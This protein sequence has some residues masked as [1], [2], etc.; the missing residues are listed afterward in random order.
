MTSGKMGVPG[1]TTAAGAERGLRPEYDVV[2]AGA[3]CAGAATA[4][5][6]ARAGMRVLMIDPV[7]RGRDA[8]STHA[9]M[10]GAVIQLHRWGLL[11]ALRAGGTPP[12]PA[13]TFDYGDEV[14][15]VP[16]KPSD[17]IDALYAPRRT[18][19]DPLLSDAAEDAGAQVVRGVSLVDL[20]RDESGRVR[21]AV[22]A[23][24]D[25]RRHFVAAD[26]VV[27]ADGVRS[28]VARLV[29]APVTHAAQHAAAT[30][31]R[32]VRGLA[33]GELRWTFRPG[34]AAGLIPT[35]DDATCVFVAVRP[36]TLAAAPRESLFA[37]VM[38]AVDPG[39][40]ER[41]RAAP[42]SGRL[43][44]FAGVPGFLRASAGP[45]WALVGDA[46]YFKDPITAHG[47]T[48]ALRDAELLARAVL[49]GT[50]ADLLGYQEERDRTSRGL[51]EVTDRIAS[52]EWSMPEVKRLHRRLSDEMKTDLE[53]IR[54]FGPPPEPRRRSA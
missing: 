35:N 29:D 37:S 8:L 48:D 28:R 54:S 53:V 1:T 7:P 11:E 4:M 31:Y 49:R 33:G 26:L 42:I 44:A 10:R 12:L 16:I 51:L 27:G 15:T 17:G 36:E 32:Y 13:T 43:R 38:E 46:G 3:R 41:V 40:W 19:L 24:A 14:V 45:G 50:E 25:R 5:L 34:M 20:E 18:V 21:G 52:L 6:L 9:L 39:Q 22:L 23:G 47:I 30:A 2:I